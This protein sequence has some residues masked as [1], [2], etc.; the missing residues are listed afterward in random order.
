MLV[1]LGC[2]QQVLHC[3]F[4]FT[5][6]KNKRIFSIFNIKRCILFFWHISQPYLLLPSTDWS[7]YSPSLTGSVK[8][9][10]SSLLHNID[11]SFNLLLKT[12]YLRVYHGLPDMLFVCYWKA[13]LHIVVVCE[14]SDA[15][16]NMVVAICKLYIIH[17]SCEPCLYARAWTDSSVFL[18]TVSGSSLNTI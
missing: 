10:T 16:N 4:F 15:K 13:Y 2:H 7:L 3:W 6:I 5:C 9:E 1:W 11:K 17:P 14:I 12:W 8:L 18:L